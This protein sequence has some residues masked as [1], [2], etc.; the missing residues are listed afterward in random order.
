MNRSDA[1]KVD[2]FTFCFETTAKDKQTKLLIKAVKLILR[3]FF[4]ENVV[5]ELLLALKEAVNN[6]VEHAYRSLDVGE[7]KVKVKLQIFPY[8]FILFEVIDWGKEFVFASNM[9]DL[10]NSSGRGIY[11][12][13]KIMDK[14]EY[15]RQDNRNHIIM[16]KQWRLNND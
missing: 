7:P 4:D 11:I 6:V 16:K 5:F 1:G 14:C 8:Q 10:V 15:K 12:M 13:Q 2:Y 3:L 9:P